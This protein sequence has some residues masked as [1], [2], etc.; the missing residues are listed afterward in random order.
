MSR[1][2]SSVEAVAER[3]GW[4]AWTVYDRARRGLLPHRKPIGTRKLLFLE[5]ELDAWDDGAQ[6]EVQELAD[7][8]RVVR[9]LTNGNGR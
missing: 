7:G 4:S 9:P 1:A 5:H 3:Y 2:Y 6:L 8:G